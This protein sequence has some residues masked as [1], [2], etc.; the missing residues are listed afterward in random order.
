MNRVLINT[1]HALVVLVPLGLI[2]WL[3][4]RDE[5][6]HLRWGL[7]GLLVI[8]AAVFL[9]QT[10]QRLWTPMHVVLITGIGWGLI[11]LTSPDTSIR[12]FEDFAVKALAWY[13]VACATWLYLRLALPRAL[14]KYQATGI[15]ILA[16]PQT[17]PVRRP[18][19]KSLKKQ[20]P[21]IR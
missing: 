16:P 12:W 19:K 11:F 2:V 13:F 7:A 10:R 6:N 5:V 18:D 15:L 14:A 3:N 17:R 21:I 9:W 8:P 20:F 1:L 4:G